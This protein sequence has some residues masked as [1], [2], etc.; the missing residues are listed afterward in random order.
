MP[1]V[2]RYTCNKDKANERIKMV[3]M[4]TYV[5]CFRNS[6]HAVID[7]ISF[8][9]TY[10]DALKILSLATI[11]FSE[12]HFPVYAELNIGEKHIAFYEIIVR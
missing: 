9:A 11:G 7:K 2:I 12:K 1:G 3:N 8:S 6:K 4:K 5:M 10:N